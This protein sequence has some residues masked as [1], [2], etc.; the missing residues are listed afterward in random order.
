MKLSA[1]KREMLQFKYQRF[2]FSHRRRKKNVFFSVNASKITNYCLNFDDVRF[3]NRFFTDALTNGNST[4]SRQR[5][6]LH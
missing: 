5:R 2:D 4:A 3:S 6:L 1:L